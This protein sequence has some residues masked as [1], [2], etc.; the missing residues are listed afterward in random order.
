MSLFH[1]TLTISRKKPPLPAGI[2]FYHLWA[3]AKANEFNGASLGPPWPET[4]R[5][6]VIL[7]LYAYKSTD[8]LQKT[9]QKHRKTLDLT[10]TPFSYAAFSILPTS[11][12]VAFRFYR[13]FL[14]ILFL[15]VFWVLARCWRQSRVLF[16]ISAIG[17]MLLYDPLGSDLRVGN[18]NVLVFSL[19]SGTLALLQTGSVKS[20]RRWWKQCSGIVLVLIGILLKPM[21]WILIVAL[22]VHLF[23]IEDWIRVRRILIVSFFSGTLLL[24]LPCLFFQDLGVWAKWFQSIIAQGDVRLSRE[25]SAGNFASL[26]LFSDLFGWSWLTTG[27]ITTLLMT[28]PIVSGKRPLARNL[29]KF[30]DPGFAMAVGLTTCIALTPLCWVHY[31]VMLILPALWLLVHGGKWGKRAALLSLGLCSGIVPPYSVFGH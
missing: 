31:F 23:L 1:W 19:F 25:V 30:R 6:E 24:A 27:F 14:V 4:Y 9:A 21:W 28:I 12:S 5:Y 3:V 8:L 22:S 29:K 13:F 16:L 11:Y 7:A 10:G 20:R 15:A 26:K 17:L 2:D 18:T